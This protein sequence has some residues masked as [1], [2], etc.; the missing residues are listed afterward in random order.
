MVSS[1]E[2]FDFITNYRVSGQPDTSIYSRIKRRAHALITPRSFFSSSLAFRSHQVLVFQNFFDSFMVM[3]YELKIDDFNMLQSLTYYLKNHEQNCFFDD[4]SKKDK[5]LLKPGRLLSYR[6]NG[7]TN[8]VNQRSLPALLSLPNKIKKVSSFHMHRDKAKYN[9]VHK[10]QMHQYLPVINWKKQ[11]AVKRDIF[12]TMII[13]KK[14]INKM[15]KQ[16][17]RT[18]SK[19]FNKFYGSKSLIPQVFLRP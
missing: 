7:F 15:N 11:T 9:K 6:V 10:S 18:S 17:F 8:A 2:Y 16:L 14:I 1:K 13:N 4:L 3:P 12:R 5:I 19:K